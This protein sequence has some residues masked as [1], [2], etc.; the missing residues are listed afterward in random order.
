LSEKAKK[1]RGR[2]RK[3]P[4]PKV[5]VQRP[6]DD[7]PHNS[8]LKWDGKVSQ[9]VNFDGRFSSVEPLKNQQPG[10]KKPYKWNH[11]A[12]QNWIMGQADP[13]GFLSSVMLGKEIFP[14]YAQDE[15]GNVKHIGKISADPEL[16]ISAA[17]TLLAKCVPDLKAVEINQTIEE[18]KVIDISALSDNDLN[19]IERVLEHAVIDGD[20]SGENAEISEAVHNGLLEHDRT[21]S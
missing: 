9:E 10:R 2:P 7:S 4:E 8:H 15:D 20:P 12:L 16:R 3:K 14:V 19:T 21:G 17:K 11:R 18:R 13:A 1:K 6:V 5:Q